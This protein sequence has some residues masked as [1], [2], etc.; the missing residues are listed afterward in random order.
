MLFEGNIGILLLFLLLTQGGLGGIG[1][2]NSMLFLL[3]L[4]ML[5][6]NGG[7]GRAYGPK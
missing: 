3:I 2:D 7:M 1:G 5:L 6:G 4:I